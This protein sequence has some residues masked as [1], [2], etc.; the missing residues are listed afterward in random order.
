V[1]PETG[2]IWENEH[3][4]LGGDEINVLEAG[5]NYGWPLVS[6]GLD[7]TGEQITDTGLTE[8]EGLNPP[9]VYWVPSIAVSGLSFY[10][11]EPFAAWQGNALVGALM[12]GRVRATGH[13]Q[14]LTFENGRAITREPILLEL[15][16]RIRDVRP[17]PDGFI[18]VLTDENPGVLLRLEPIQ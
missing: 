11:G 14:R 15:R 6:Y 12:R 2:D 3:G 8:L 4:P 1:H 9:L 5:G 13:F 7:Y 16:Q 10:E 18:Y 17:G